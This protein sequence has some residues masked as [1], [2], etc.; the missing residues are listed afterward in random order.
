VP[1]AAPRPPLAAAASV[2]LRYV[3]H[4]GII[5]RGPV[6]G[7]QYSFTAARPI[8]PVDAQDAPALLRTSWFK[9]A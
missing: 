1:G 8:Q 9:R 2:A 6:S 3:K 4:G 5:L 7:R